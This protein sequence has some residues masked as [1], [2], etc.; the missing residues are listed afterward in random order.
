M[1]LSLGKRSVKP[2]F[3]LVVLKKREADLKLKSLKFV[4]RPLLTNIDIMKLYQNKY[5]NQEQP[6]TKKLLIL[7]FALWSHPC[8]Y[9][10]CLKCYN[11]CIHNTYYNPV[12]NWW[13]L[14]CLT[15]KKCM[16]W[17]LSTSSITGTQANNGTASE[18]THQ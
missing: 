16:V 5:P 9:S 12:N 8:E 2:Q 4:K 3:R 11:V 1:F 15:S 7:L 18:R 6:N 17:V 14:R 13:R 10:F